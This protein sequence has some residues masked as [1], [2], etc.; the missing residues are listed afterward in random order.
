MGLLKLRQD[1]KDLAR[2]RQIVGILAKEGFH[3]AM[4]RSRLLKHAP[5]ASRLGN[6]Q[7]TTPQRVRETLEKLGPTFVKL[8]QTLSLRP[9]LIPQEYSD[10]FRKLQD[11][12]PP[13][14]YPVVKGIVESELQRPL[15]TVFKTFKQDPVAAAS[16][17][18]V[19][20]AVLKDGT[21]VAV[22]VMRPGIR[23]MMRR[24]IDIMDYIAG[25]V[26]RHYAWIR[27]RDI[28]KEFKG[29]TAREL[30]LAFELR[31][32]KRFHE[33]FKDSEDVVIPDVYEELCSKELLVMEYVKGVPLSD[34]KALKKRK[35]DLKRLARIGVDTMFLQVFDLGVFHADPHPG[36][37]LALRKGRHQRLAFLDF[38]IVGFIDDELR[39]SFLAMLQGLV[40][41]NVRTVTRALLAI[42]DRGRSCDPHQLERALSTIIMDWHGTTLREQR[43]SE[44]L[45]KVVITGIAHDIEMPPDVVLMAKAF[46]T[47]EGAGAWLDPSINLTERAKPFLEAK[48]KERH[49]PRAL[50]RE[51][52]A[53]A[54]DLRLLLKEL[55]Y[56]AST[57]MSKIEEGKIELSMDKDEF[58]RMERDRELETSRKTLATTSAAFFLGSAFIAALAQELTVLGF[59][60]WQLGMAGF[61][62][63]LVMLGVVTMK[64]HKYVRS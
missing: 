25:K 63:T 3:D 53:G 57:L 23:D 8:G 64:S 32:I 2:L 35:Y 12:V 52:S 41:R 48:I 1:I 20:E 47:I 6:G 14:S 30:D 61:I 56:A 24:D 59:P 28:V 15:K 33:F 9:D 16:V 38:G 10:E 45:R 40:T 13:M 37:L 43:A 29:Y 58:R 27:A 60:L 36:N 4:A 19:H 62:V 44:L 46:V 49:G 31:N 55:P 11:A 17:A 39:E 50:E 5:L 21:R 18:Q 42:G 34:K 26:D 54:E 51:L 22:K 7:P